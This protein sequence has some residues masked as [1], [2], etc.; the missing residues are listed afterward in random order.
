MCSTNE[1]ISAVNEIYIYKIIRV[2]VRG[3]EEG[4][5]RQTEI[6]VNQVDQE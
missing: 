1:T 4:K 2:R 3:E 5:M 6:S